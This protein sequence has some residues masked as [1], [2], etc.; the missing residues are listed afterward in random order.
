MKNYKN[1]N[2]EIEIR[3]LLMIKS[4]VLQYFHQTLKSRI[5]MKPIIQLL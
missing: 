5:K 1:E 3:V 2:A 4:V